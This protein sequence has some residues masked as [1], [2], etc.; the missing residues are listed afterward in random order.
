[1]VLWATTLAVPAAAQVTTAPAADF[2][3]LIRADLRTDKPLIQAGQPVW[4]EFILINQTD[5]RLTLRV[6]DVSVETGEYPEMGLPIEHVFSGRG[7]T[8]PILEDEFGERHD[9]KAGIKPRDTVPAIKLAPHGSVGLRLDLTQYYGSLVRP[10]K[11]RLSWQPYSGSIASEPLAITVLAERQAV[12]LTDFGK[13]TVRFYYD[14]AP[15]HVQNFIELVEQRFYDNLTF[16]RIIP[17]GLIQGG[18]PIG[19]RRGVRTD[20]KRL[21]AEFNKIPFEMGTVGMCRSSQDPDSASCQFFICLGRQ[22]S[23][24][25]QQTVFGYLVG[26]ASLE[27]L[28]RIAA[29]PTGK[30]QGLDDCPRKPVYIRAIS[31]ENVPTRQRSQGQENP[32]APPASQPAVTIS[33]EKVSTAVSPRPAPNAGTSRVAGITVSASESAPA[34]L[35]PATSPAVAEP[36]RGLPGL[37]ATGRIGPR[38]TGTA[39][40]HPTR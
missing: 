26:D 5:N 8:G 14:Q 31:L 17:G 24:D 22:P 39:A 20:G 32:S 6:P 7:F 13:M 29:V 36:G 38:R 37:K 3:A 25:E 30:I 11:Y 35:T 40:S 19:N 15:N 2:K 1:M 34:V 4:V 16:N 33:V 18:D 9:S 10:G 21:K 12:I 27:T 28:R 23:F